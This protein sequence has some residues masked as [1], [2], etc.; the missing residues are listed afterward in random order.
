LL[1]ASFT[2]LDILRRALE[3][4]E[5]ADETPAGFFI[6]SPTDWATIELTKSTQGEYIVGS[7]GGT[8]SAP[9]LWGKP[10]IVSADDLDDD[11][12]D[13]PALLEGDD[14]EAA[15][16]ES[17]ALLTELQQLVAQAGELASA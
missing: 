9:S 11:E 14:S 3:Q 6:L 8:A 1:G 4:V 2:K 7:P 10:V 5:L 16:V 12:A 17:K 13:D 15:D